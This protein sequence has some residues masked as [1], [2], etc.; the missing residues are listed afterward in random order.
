MTS[1]CI[2]EEYPVLG[3]RIEPI[4]EQKK[5][6]KIGM[7]HSPKVLSYEYGG[8]YQSEVLQPWN[9]SSLSAKCLRWGW[10]NPGPVHRECGIFSHP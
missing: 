3:S 8:G 9:I 2:T 4:F 7:N 6:K 5:K 10:G 1:K